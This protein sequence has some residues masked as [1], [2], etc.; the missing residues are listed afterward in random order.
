MSEV[1]DSHG[2]LEAIFGLFVLV[3]CQAG[4]VD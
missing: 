2:H 1:V 3:G 4:V